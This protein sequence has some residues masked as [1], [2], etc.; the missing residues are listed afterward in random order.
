MNIRYRI[1]PQDDG[2]YSIAIG[3]G[4]SDPYIVPGFKSEVKAEI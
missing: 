2:T 1:I 4:K 3:E